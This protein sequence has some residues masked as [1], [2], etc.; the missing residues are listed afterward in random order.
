MVMEF[1]PDKD[2]INCAKHMPMT[3]KSENALKIT[4]ARLAATRANVTPAFL[5]AFDA[6]TDADIAA[7]IASNP[8]QNRAV[9]FDR[10]CASLSGSPGF[11]K[12]H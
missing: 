4:P 11:S 2:A 8:G 3:E 9:I 12:S 1:D 5:A 7:Q 6:M 10:L